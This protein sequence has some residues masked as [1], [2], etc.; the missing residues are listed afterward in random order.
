MAGTTPGYIAT[1]LRTTT[2]ATGCVVPIP[3]PAGASTVRATASTVVA[4]AA[5]GPAA[6]AGSSA[7]G[8]S[9]AD[10]TSR[11]APSVTES[12]LA[13]PHF[14]L[15]GDVTV[16]ERDG[17]CIATA[18]LGE[19]SRDVGVGDTPQEAV[20]LRCGGWVSCTRAR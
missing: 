6:G 10:P 16:Y 20:G 14:D 17:R 8:S 9:T 7:M 2:T 5:P 13:H 1:T 11:P 3:R 19:D 4:T 12:R 15:Y 18:D